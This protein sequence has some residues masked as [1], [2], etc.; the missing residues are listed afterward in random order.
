MLFKYIISKI[1]RPFLLSS[2]MN[3]PA[4]KTKN[5]FI[6][7]KW[8]NMGRIALMIWVRD[9]YRVKYRRKEVCDHQKIK[10]IPKHEKIPYGWRNMTLTEGKKYENQI[11]TMLKSWSRVSFQDGEIRSGEKITDYTFYNEN[12]PYTGELFLIQW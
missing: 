9:D 1:K 3:P 6:L 4:G 2:K 12:S 5:G 10:I 7:K 11:K 8:G